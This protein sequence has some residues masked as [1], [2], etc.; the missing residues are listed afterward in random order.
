MARAD[1]LEPT[2]D[3]LDAVA[4]AFLG[5]QFTGRNYLDWPIEKRLDRY[6]IHQGMGYLL[7][8]GSSYNA[9]MERVMANIGQAYRRGVLEAHTE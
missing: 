7:K 6:L 5:S 3:L 8:D 9:L 2:S 1:D 4:W